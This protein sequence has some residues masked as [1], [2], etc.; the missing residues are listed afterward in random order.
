MSIRI[1][2]APCCWGV[3][4]VKNPHLPPWR[5]VVEE[6][7]E[8]GYGGIELGPY[9]FLPLDIAT[10]SEAL[11]LHGLSVVAGT[12]RTVSRTAS[13]VPHASTSSAAALARLIRC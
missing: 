8:A 1:A 10:V 6:A 7:S 3:D 2:S 9:G 12:W 11:E 4:D 13:A 5:R